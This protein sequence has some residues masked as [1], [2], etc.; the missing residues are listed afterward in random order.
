MNLKEALEFIK[1]GKLVKLTKFKNFAIGSVSFDDMIYTFKFKNG[2]YIS[3]K[4]FVTGIKDARSKFWKL[5][6]IDKSLII[7]KQPKK[8]KRNSKIPIIQ[9]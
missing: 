1:E 2:K 7:E 4:V 6:D 3:D 5:V 9:T 8:N